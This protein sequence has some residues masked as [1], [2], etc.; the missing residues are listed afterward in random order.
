MS[1]EPVVPTPAAP[2]NARWGRLRS[3]LG[4]LSDRGWKHWAWAGGLI[5]VGEILSC[6]LDEHE[7]FLSARYLV[8]QLFQNHG[9][10]EVKPRYTA[11][12]LV[13]DDAYW[14]QEFQAR[15]PIDR[16]LLAS[17]VSKVAVHN[18]A[19]IVLDFDLSTGDETITTPVEL[20]NGKVIELRER[21][22]FAD[23]TLKLV[24]A[25]DEAAAKRTVVLPEEIE[26]D[27]NNGWIRLADAY[28]GYA[29]TSKKV[30]LAHIRFDSDVRKLPTLAKLNAG[31][32]VTSLSI[33]AAAAFRPGAFD[34]MNWDAD[35]FAGFM[36][37]DEIPQV[38]ASEI[39]K[40]D[41]ANP[42]T[43]NMDKL[44]HKVVL[45]GGGW[46]TD[47][48]H[49]GTATVD[50][51]FTP[52]G[53]MPGVF[54]HAN[55]VESLLDERLLTTVNTIACDMIVGIISAVLLALPSIAW[56]RSLAIV[57]V[58]TV[59]V[60]L[61][62]FSVQLFGVYFDVFIIDALLLLHIAVETVRGWYVDHVAYATAVREGRITG[63]VH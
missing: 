19:V 36:K 42:D 58:I 29:F 49:R 51:H 33:A 20:P 32:P 15:V 35:S 54:V 61:C 21:K 4:A 11:V 52:V 60:V 55:Y 62:Y 30:K 59:P 9:P 47:G 38:S 3:I 2:Q 22:V 17:L 6:A 14:K 23:E 31:G 53:S 44:Q 43:A 57:G 45:I 7:P 25:V 34:K 26:L 48:N 13:Q 1:N 63:K 10:R 50:S 56:K 27:D 41:D 24:L 12:V 28:D 8:F 39:L 16:A 18:P 37:S 5:V 46:H 40:T